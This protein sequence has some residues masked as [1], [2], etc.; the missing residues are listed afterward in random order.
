[1][2]QRSDARKRADKII[3]QIN[4]WHCEK[5]EE[6]VDTSPL[7]TMEDFLNGMFPWKLSE[8]KGF[9]IRINTSILTKQLILLFR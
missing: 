2:R 8:N 5:V 4:K 1:M 3:K 6:D 7:V 9:Q